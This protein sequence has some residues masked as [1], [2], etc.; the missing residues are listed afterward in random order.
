[1]PGI[2]YDFTIAQG[3]GVNINYVYKDDVGAIVNLTGYTGK[4]QI[5]KTYDSPTAVLDAS[6]AN[7]KVTIDVPTGKVTI[8]W[9]GSETAD[10]AAGTHVW[11]H[12]LYPPAG[13]PEQMLYGTVD[14]RPRVTQ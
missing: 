4:A 1:M 11:D 2:K 5:R 3:E 7:A 10:V 8:K 9:P 14:V 6:S 12:F 13:E